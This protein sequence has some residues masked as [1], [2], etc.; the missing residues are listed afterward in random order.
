MD[1]RYQI[2][3]SSTYTDLIEERDHVMHAVLEL[4]CFP[5]GME[6]FQAIDRKQ[7]DHIKSVINECDYYIL[8]IGARYGSMDNKG[9]SYTE[10]EYNY[11]VRKKIPVLAFL[12]S[13]INLV[14]F[15]KADADKVLREKLEKFRNKVKKGRLVHFWSDPYELKSKV[16]S[17]LVEVFETH[18]QNGWVRA[19]SIVIN[20]AQLEIDRLQKEVTEHQNK[21]KRLEDDLNNKNNKIL[22]L[23]TSYQAPQEDIKD[24]LIKLENNNSFQ[25]NSQPCIKTFSVNDVQFNMVYVGGGMFLMGANDDE[26]NA[27]PKEKPVHGVALSDY[28][29]GET[30]VTQALWQAVMGKNPS[31]FKGDPNLPVERVSWEDSR[32]FIGK[33]SKLTGMEFH[34]PTEAQW[35]FAARGGN[36]GK[37][38]LYRFAGSNDYNDVA[39]FSD[40]SICTHPVGILNPNELGLYDMMGNVWEWCED[41]YDRL[42]Y[43]HSSIFDPKGPESKLGNN[44]DRVI[45]GGS[46]YNNSRLCGVYIRLCAAQTYKQNNIGLRLALSFSPF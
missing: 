2:F 14:P 39:W 22:E 18:P 13:D 42:Y 6:L 28:W 1:K 29:M 35:E 37:G 45:R 36:L 31:E 24:L 17:S 11:A 16:V 25:A 20:D 21:I 3:I 40:N 43:I 38:N 30:L 23:T 32:T 12:H 41:R 10:K 15:G 34:L 5:V 8:I 26:K 46:W 7:F 19:N 44:Y 27:S 33:L 9:I 4:K